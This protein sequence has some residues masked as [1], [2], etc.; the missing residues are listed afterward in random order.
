MAGDW[1]KM[2]I[3]LET[4]PEVIGVASD[5]DISE[6]HVCGLLF[7]LW[8]WADMHTETGNAVSV[9]SIWLDRFIGADGFTESLLRVGWLEGLDNAYSFPQFELHNGN[10]AKKR[11]NTSK[12]VAKHRDK[13]V[14]LS[15]LPEKKRLEKKRIRNKATYSDVFER[16][17]QM[18]PKRRRQGKAQAAKS[19]EQAVEHTDAGT[20][21]TALNGFA[22]SQKARG[23]FCPMPSTWLNQ[24]RWLDDPAS[25]ADSSAPPPPVKEIT[26]EEKRRKRILWDLNNELKA[27]VKA[28]DGKTEKA[29][30]LKMEISKYEE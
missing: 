8:S 4:S 25:W 10:S 17:W 24:E 19:F 13:T 27:M 22:T 9:T 7:K 16:F 11:A 1:I 12:R 26:D 6:T 28:G 3:G 20:I 21:L 23:D 14:T 18:Y 15:A 29:E 5:L 2:R 30:L